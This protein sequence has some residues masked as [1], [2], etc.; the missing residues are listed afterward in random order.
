MHVVNANKVARMQELLKPMHL[1][2]RRAHKQASCGQLICQKLQ[3]ICALLEFEDIREF[4]D[5]CLYTYSTEISLVCQRNLR[6][7]TLMSH[8]KSSAFYSSLVA[9]FLSATPLTL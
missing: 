1:R 4:C 7:N 6:K 9:N 8:W 2:R 5:L 3:G